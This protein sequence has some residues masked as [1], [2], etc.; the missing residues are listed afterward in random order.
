M[1]K[2]CQESQPIAMPK[3]PNSYLIHVSIPATYLFCLFC[4]DNK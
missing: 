2:P 3:T 4:D 1:L